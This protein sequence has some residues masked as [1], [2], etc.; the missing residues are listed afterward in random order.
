MLSNASF[1]NS[2]LMKYTMKSFAY[3]LTLWMSLILMQ[4]CIKK[5]GDHYPEK[6]LIPGLTP[7]VRLNPD[8]TTLF[9]QDFF[10]NE[11]W[12]DSLQADSALQLTLSADKKKIFITIKRDVPLL[13]NLRLYAQGFAYDILLKRSPKVNVSITFN[14]KPGVPEPKKVQLAADFNGW[15]PASTSFKPGRDGK[16]EC[17]VQLNPGT[18]QYQLVVDDKWMLDPDNPNTADNHVGGINSLLTVGKT[19]RD[20]F[21]VMHTESFNPHNIN[22]TCNNNPDSVF[23]YW[24]NHRITTIRHKAQH[25]TSDENNKISIDIP[26]AASKLKQSWIRI[27]AFNKEGESN[28]ILIPLES[29]KVITDAQHLSADDKYK[30]IMYF[31]MVDRFKDGDTSINKPLQDERV[32]IKANYQ[33]GDL[34]GIAE[35][36]RDGYFTQLGI[37]CIWISPITQN[38]RT[39]YQEY[40]APH[41]WYSGYHGYWPISFTTVDDRF[42]NAASLDTL[43]ALA[44]RNHIKVILDFVSNHVHEENP[45]YKN[46]PEYFVPVD[47]PDGRKNIRIW[48]EHRLTT[49][50]DTFMPDID[51]SK[52]EVVNLMVDSSVYWIKRFKLDGFRH[53]A[54]KHVP[55]V[56]WRALTKKLKEEIIIPEERELLQIGETFGSRE[57]IASY[58]SGGMQD[59]QFDFNL[60]FDARSVLALDSPSFQ[61]LRNSMYSS[62]NY[63]GWHSLMGNITGNHDITRFISLASGAMTFQEN[64]R[65]AGWNRIIRIESPVGYYR[66]M[67]L[68][69]FNMT[70]PGI[71]VTYYGDEIGDPGANDPDNRRMMRFDQLLQQELNVKSVVERLGK[72]RAQSMPLLYGDLDILSCSDTHLV[73][74]RRYFNQHVIVVFNKSRQGQSITFNLP[75][76]IS[77]KNSK[78]MLGH[79]LI[80]TN[81]SVT[82]NMPA[83]SVE[84]I[85]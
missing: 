1:L 18:Y 56:F 83:V 36:I 28:D 64:D 27:Y 60:Y 44:H 55:E 37:N 46:H 71:P 32:S 76:G 9:T 12:L 29:G 20:K 5:D 72:L 67:Q 42:G 3:P 85:Y 6:S 33:G 68:Q 62:F 2:T 77:L 4:S 53:D 39:A 61:L 16:W 63:Y 75:D 59:A 38:P 30:T 14:Q 7:P 40:P 10:I 66:L 23:A 48:D 17:T 58:V 80:Y 74:I 26:V 24:Q 35:K 65:E 22:I 84:V 49:W 82:I 19:D 79:K 21:P 13:S 45:L 43:V 52:P 57:L 54:T 47:L 25:H 31:M 41:R 11:Q 8:T 70:M 50:F 51:Y 34:A 15:T 78:S 69:A 81:H 73:Y